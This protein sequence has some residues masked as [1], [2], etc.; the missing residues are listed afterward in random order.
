MICANIFAY[1]HY[2]LLFI[3]RTQAF[4]S[5]GDS[6][7]IFAVRGC[8]CGVFLLHF[9][10]LSIGALCTL[11]P[12]RCGSH[13]LLC[14]MSSGFR[15][16]IPRHLMPTYSVYFCGILSRVSPCILATFL[17]SLAAWFSYSSSSLI[18]YFRPKTPQKY[19]FLPKPRFK[20]CIFQ[21]FVV[22]LHSI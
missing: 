9:S 6:W 8:T 2:F 12:H 1:M 7:R 4:T 20:I 19:I 13:R 16:S 11:S 10:R 14:R 3:A 21:K 22:S 17:S 18:V 5:G 15:M